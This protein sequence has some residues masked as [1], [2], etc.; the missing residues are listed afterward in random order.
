MIRRDE[1]IRQIKS[2]IKNKWWVFFGILLITHCYGNAGSSLWSKSDEGDGILSVPNIDQYMKEWRFKDIQ[3][4][5]PM[6]YVDVGRNYDDLWWQI[7]ITI[8]DFNMDRNYHITSSIWKVFD[9]S[10]SAFRHQTSPTGNLLHLCYIKNKPEQIGTSFKT[11]SL[12][13]K[14]VSCSV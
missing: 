6:M 11:Y 4:F 5:I 9:E 2:V 13:I 3:K 10:M 1:I 7:V 8:E 12:P 14:Q